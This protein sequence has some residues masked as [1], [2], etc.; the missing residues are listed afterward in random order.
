MRATSLPCRGTH[1]SAFEG[2][3]I[4]GEA[5]AAAANDCGCYFADRDEYAALWIRDMVANIFCA[6]RSRNREVGGVLDGDVLGSA[7]GIG[8]W[9]V[10]GGFLGTKADNYWSIA[11]NDCNWKRVSV[12]QG[13]GGVSGGGILLMVPIYVL[14]TLL[15]AI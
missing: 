7:A 5:S 12:Y 2:V 9:G 6:G 11:G 3:G 10:H 4:T 8:D 13:S 14:V 15:F 1:N